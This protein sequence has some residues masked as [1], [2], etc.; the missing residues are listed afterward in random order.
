[1]NRYSVYLSIA[2]VSTASHPDVAAANDV[3]LQNARE[4]KELKASL[5]YGSSQTDQ[6]AELEEL[7]SSP[8]SKLKVAKTGNE[9]ARAT[10]GGGGNRTSEP[11]TSD[12]TSSVANPTESKKGFLKRL[13]EKKEEPQ[14]SVSEGDAI[15]VVPLTR[16]APNS[17][18]GMNRIEA[19]TKSAPTLEAGDVH[20]QLT[21][22]AALARFGNIGTV[23]KK[24]QTTALI[25]EGVPGSGDGSHLPRR[26]SPV[27]AKQTAMPVPPPDAPGDFKAEVGTEAPLKKSSIFNRFLYGRRSGG[28]REQKEVA[29]TSNG[30]GM[31]PN[32]AVN[33]TQ[34][35]EPFNRIGDV[36]SE[37]PELAQAQSGEGGIPVNFFKK[38]FTERSAAQAGPKTSSGTKPSEETPATGSTPSKPDAPAESDGYAPLASFGPAESSGASSIELPTKERNDGPVIGSGSSGKLFKKIFASKTDPVSTEN[39][40]AIPSPNIPSSVD[41]TAT[42]PTSDFADISN[43]DPGIQDVLGTPIM[44]A[45]GDSGDSNFIPVGAKKPRQIGYATVMEKLSDGAVWSKVRIPEIGEGYVPSSELRP[46][47]FDETISFIRKRRETATESDPG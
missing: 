27:V 17:T 33:A 43:F 9:G 18:Q 46:A 24:S 11:M 15:D 35:T 41:S 32:L 19:K 10:E 34:G 42:P 5:G 44:V 22:D 16:S 21:P 8:F 26:E 3:V 31:D 2:L 1:M 20:Q 14:N 6:W 29:E 4:M 36:N 13:I 38:L 12:A 25:P 39:A 37:P 28:D 30:E 45:I 7:K 40:V 23:A 47:S